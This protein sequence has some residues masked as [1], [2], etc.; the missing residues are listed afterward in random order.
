MVVSCR[1][2]VLLTSITSAP[3]LA[4]APEMNRARFVRE[5]LRA[6]WI[7]LFIRSSFDCWQN[8]G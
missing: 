4:W 1:I 6:L 8:E 5:M 3:V 7:S 2:F